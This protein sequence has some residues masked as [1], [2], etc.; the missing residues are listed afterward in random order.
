MPEP[1]YPTK[2]Q[3]F[4]EKLCQAGCQSA[5]SHQ[6]SIILSALCKLLDI[7]GLYIIIAIDHIILTYDYIIIIVLGLL[8]L[9]EECPTGNFITDADIAYTIYTR[10]NCILQDS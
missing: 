4:P 1:T 7:P 3:P 10:H 5:L 8:I 6:T 2:T 9:Y